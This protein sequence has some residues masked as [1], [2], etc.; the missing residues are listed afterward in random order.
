MNMAMK[1]GIAVLMIAILLCLHISAS[2]YQVRSKK[3][4]KM[5][6]DTDAGGD[7]ALALLL[8]LMYEV[9]T[10]DIEILAITCTYGNAYLNNVT[11]NVLKVLT[12]ANRNDI[13][14]YKGS[15]KPMINTYKF[16]DYFGEDGFGDFNFTQR[17]TAKVDESKHASVL[18]VDLVKK[19]PGEITIVALG[20]VTNIAVANM[21][22]PNF[23]NYTEQLV[24][25]GSS[26]NMSDSNG[27]PRIEFNFKQDPESNWITLNNTDKV[28]TVVPIDIVDSYAITK[29]EYRDLFNK[30]NSSFAN[31]LQLAERKAL[32]V[33]E[34]WRPADGMAMAIALKPEIAMKSFETNLVPVLIEDMRGAVVVD[35]NNTIH[36]ACVI[37][38]FDVA[39]FK[40]LI[41]E[42]LS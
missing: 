5:I 26:V 17:I 34:F 2:N 21:L 33:S 7:D 3:V 1:Y 18:L 28:H 42:C 37:Q 25:M 12:I 14:V 24:I 35:P 8:A 16:D 38:E 23:L 30:L 40:N 4:R 6:I 11:Q 10:N 22:E 13:P 31:F 20:P 19:Y 39:A 15:V 29:E 32:E 41:L 27:I 36:N 9:K